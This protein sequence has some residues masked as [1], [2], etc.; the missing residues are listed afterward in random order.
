MR[1]SLI[2]AEIGKGVTIKPRQ[3]IGSA[4]PHKTARVT[5]NAVDIVISEPVNGRVR[6]D[7]Q[8][9]TMSDVGQ[10]NSEE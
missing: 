4:E 1:Q 8:A 7:G 10:A 5:D 9:F 3:S 6:F 2:G